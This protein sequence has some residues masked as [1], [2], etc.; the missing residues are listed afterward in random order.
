MR[1]M[2]EVPA[3][4]LAAD[5]AEVARLMTEN[6]IAALATVLHAAER[7]AGTPG[8]FA[9]PDEA[10]ELERAIDV[11]REMLAQDI[12]AGAL[13]AARGPLFG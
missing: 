1:H 9:D 11:V 6:P 3:A 13:L 5:Q 12:G 10:G 7:A 4:Q 2:H 8:F